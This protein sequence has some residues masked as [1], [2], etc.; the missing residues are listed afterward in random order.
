VKPAISCNMLCAGVC[1]PDVLSQ[2]K[3]L[4][5]LLS[6]HAGSSDTLGF[7][8]ALLDFQL[9]MLGTAP[10]DANKVRSSA[11]FTC[12]SCRRQEKFVMTS[13]AGN[14]SP[15]VTRG[16]SLWFHMHSGSSSGRPKPRF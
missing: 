4:E 12:G 11:D 13:H 6:R 3:D 2:L 16:D 15:P 1:N 5:S 14:L 10:Q 7:L 8:Q 9:G